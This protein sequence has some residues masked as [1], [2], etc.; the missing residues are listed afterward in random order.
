MTCEHCSHCKEAAGNVQEAANLFRPG[1]HLIHPVRGHVVYWRNDVQRD[2]TRG[3]GHYVHSA[4][5]PNRDLFWVNGDDFELAT[6]E[7]DLPESVA[8]FLAGDEWAAGLLAEIATSR[9]PYRGGE[10][11]T[12]VYGKL[13]DLAR[14][15]YWARDMAQSGLVRRSA[16]AVAG[17]VATALDNS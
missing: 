10:R 17:R 1:T 14:V 6:L 9:R 2:G 8:T 11:L 12:L 5:D 16:A 3:M 7:M 13:H 4:D 15:I